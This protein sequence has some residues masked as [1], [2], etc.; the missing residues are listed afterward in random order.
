M[1]TPLSVIGVIATLV[2]IV[3]DCS[4][5]RNM[6]ALLSSGTISVAFAFVCIMEKLD[7]TDWMT[8]IMAFFLDGAIVVENF[9]GITELFNT[10]TI[11]FNKLIIIFM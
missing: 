10:I 4:T 6:M 2:G 9:D 1:M 11:I 8:I 3:V 7:S 5:D